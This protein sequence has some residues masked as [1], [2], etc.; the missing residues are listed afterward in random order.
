M[1]RCILS[2]LQHRHDL[3]PTRPKLQL[4]CPPPSLCTD[5]G[6]MVACAGIDKLLLGELNN[7]MTFSCAADGT[8]VECAMNMT[9]R[10][11]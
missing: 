8:Y 10:Y 1:F 5:N 2:I 6:V 11:I 9:Y 3:D 4:V 7:K